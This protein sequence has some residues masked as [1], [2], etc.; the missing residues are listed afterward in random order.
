MLPLWL[1]REVYREYEPG[2]LCVER[3]AAC[4]LLENQLTGMLEKL[5]G[6]TGEVYE[7]SAASRV[8]DGLIRVTLTGECR[9]EIGLEIAAQHQ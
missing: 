2:D 5:I 3:D 1:T 8:A 9:E 6:E 4:A 7:T